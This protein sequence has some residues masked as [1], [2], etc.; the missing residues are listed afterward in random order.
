VMSSYELAE[1][2]SVADGFD[3]GRPAGAAGRLP[4]PV[5]ASA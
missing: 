5:F 4:S 2:A 3:A 1:M